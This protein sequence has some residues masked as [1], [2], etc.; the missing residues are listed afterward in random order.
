MII[1]SNDDKTEGVFTMTQ[2]KIIL[3]NM[4]PLILIVTAP[5]YNPIMR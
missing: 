4:M 1:K 3:K 2:S 5:G